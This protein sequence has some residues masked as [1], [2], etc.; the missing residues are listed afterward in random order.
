VFKTNYQLT[1]ETCFCGAIL[2]V[3][4]SL[5]ARE[6][7]ARP[8]VP[9]ASLSSS[10][11]KD[12]VGKR[13]LAEKVF[14]EAE[15]LCSDG[16]ADS[17]RLALAKYQQAIVLWTKTDDRERQGTAL[18]RIG[19]IYS[20]L[21]ESKQALEYF[22]R[23]QKL[24][25]TFSSARCNLET[26]N[27]L[28][29]LYMFLGD[30]DKAWEQC[31]VA[32][33]LSRDSS[34]RA[35]E[36]QALNNIGE[37]YYFRGNRAKAV[38]QYQ[39]ALTIWK[40]LD[41]LKG[42][43]QTFLFLGYS[44]TDLSDN[45]LAANNYAHALA[46][47]EKAN[48]LQG[49]AQTLTAIGNMHNSNGDRQV[50]LEHY[51]RAAPLF[52]LT[53]DRLGEARA[54]N[55]MGFI[56]NE[57][58]ERKRAIEYYQQA[59]RLFRDLGY[60]NGEAITLLLIGYVDVAIQDYTAALRDFQDSLRL[61][62]TIGDQRIEASLLS[63]IALVRASSGDINGAFEDSRQA[64]ALM[65]IL[66][67]RYRESYTLGNIA[68]LQERNGANQQALNSY[69]EAL[70]LSKA[71]GD[72]PGQSLMLFNIARVL[73]D[74]GN[75]DQARSNV[76]EA[77]EI[78][79][80]LRTKVSGD[81]MR[82]LYSATVHRLYDFYVDLLMRL[83][84]SRQ[85]EGFVVKAFEASER[86]RA[87]SLLE[88]LSEGRENIREGVDAALLKREHD[89]RRRIRES[90]AQRIQSAENDTSTKKVTE[91]EKQL[92]ELATEYQQVQ[93]LI[94]ASSPRYS[95]L[96]QP[97]PLSLPQVQQSV[98]DPETV[99]LE[100]SLGEERSYVWTV[101]RDSI[102]SFELPARSRI[103]SLS[104]RA[105][106]LLTAPNLSVK[107]ETVQQR[108]IR[109]RL[110]DEEF[111]RTSATLSQMI[112]GPVVGELNQKR[113]VIV[114]DGALQYLPFPALPSP[115]NF[116]TSTTA[117]PLIVDHE[118]VLLPSASALG[119]MREELRGRQP[120]PK[121]IAILAD[122]VFDKDDARLVATTKIGYRNR[123][124]NS[125][126]LTVAN[127]QTRAIRSFDG[128]GS[129]RGTL[130]RLPFSRREADAIKSLI[131]EK[132]VML[133][134]GFRAS[135]A[136]AT[137]P[138]L[139]QYRYVHFATHGLLNSEQPELSG[140]LLS[141]YDEFGKRQN[142]FLQLHDVYNLKLSADLVVLSACETALG[143][144]IRGEG[145][146]GL[147][148]GFMYAGVPRIVASL[149]NV[150]DAA[151][152]ELMGMFYKAMLTEGKRP[153]EALRTAQVNMWRT[154][155]WSSPYYWAAFT[156]QG[157]WK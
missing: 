6:L 20:R 130:G 144:D 116:K 140:I 28:S 146:V 122:A 18:R 80:T 59:R 13:Q 68:Y 145:L 38:E 17:C 62:R 48:D 46:L 5:S 42:Q 30:T 16:K 37:V 7:P 142:G 21:G 58:G 41:D 108:Q 69:N 89:L 2:V 95:A 114:A 60:K 135:V 87:R 10:P 153:A 93:G 25:E 33:K 82:A 98:L 23:S 134:L 56:Y 55:G 34:D 127:A 121:T 71:I 78:N 106:E 154:N 12:D 117:A 83:Y 85:D 36:A 125:P 88:L 100:Y 61:I 14:A 44:F 54:L 49:R 150:D 132:D 136:T 31:E 137:S 72:R 138:E 9:R 27:E 102:K 151:T 91:L 26:R 105:Y 123:N 29:S 24:C 1:F 43:A 143:K 103:E 104:R 50:A 141:S 99:L 129:G 120:A 53:G 107:D 152:A 157:E 63:Q 45:E 90:T 101:T 94:R 109:I 73:R 118:I 22:I 39:Q 97:V 84:T 65:R 133:A 75:L 86:G 126:E 4:Y 155:Q 128:L 79:D 15:R 92:D 139:S 111:A 112:L 70:A 115:V 64:L 11:A 124:K 156:L 76:E 67:D 57:L 131:P 52:R 77:L 66:K 113:I 96:V 110:A 19:K 51:D 81:E 47:F 147:T 32:L 149:W 119:L 8:Q 40:E 74:L 35:G 3:L 148:R